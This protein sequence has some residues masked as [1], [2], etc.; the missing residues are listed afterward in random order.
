MHV[1]HWDHR[2]LT[3][4]RPPEVDGVTY[5]SRSAYDRRRL[6]DLVRDIDPDIVYVS[7]WMDRDYLSACRMLRRAGVPVVS[8]FDDQWTGTLRQRVASFMPDALRTLHFSHAWVFGPYQFEFAA[9][10]GFR[11]HETIFDCCSAD[12]ALFNDA[13]RKAAPIRRVRYPHRFICVARFDSVKGVDLL[14]TAWKNIRRDRRD[15]ELCFIGNGS[16]APS[17]AAEPDVTVKEFIQPDQLVDEVAAAGCLVLPSRKEP[18]GV[19]LHEFAAAG[20]P[21]ICSDACGAAPMFVVPGNNGYI[22]EA[23]SVASLER[24]LL[25]I[26]NTND[27]ELR[28]MSARSHEYGQRITPAMT[29]ASFLSIVRR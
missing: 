29:A 18:W 12:L 23:G 1:V 9:R 10:L 7:G 5:Y 19:V 22:C 27:D 21:I 15:W 13:H 28:T 26:I 14:V 17:L 4:Y 24:G 20:L 16:L 2:K 11:K 3:P 8:G 25:R 6:M